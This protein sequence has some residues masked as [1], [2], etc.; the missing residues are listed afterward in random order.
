MLE[1]HP[2][3]AF[4]PPNAQ[5][6]ILGSFPGKQSSVS[7]TDSW[8]W[9]YGNPRNH[10]W[11]ILEGVYGV[12]LKDIN[13]KKKLLRSLGMAITDIIYQCERKLGSN[14]DANLT[15]IVYNTDAIG[16]ILA[17][18]DIEKIFFSSRFV[19]SNF[20][21]HFRNLT[22]RY[23]DLELITLPSPSP[24]YATMALAEKAKRYQDLLPKP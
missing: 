2:F 6:L 16:K 22:Q 23:P 1:T 9:F 21:S 19:E 14:L 12:K 3:G 17:E 11:Q 24:R 20:K 10:F 4:V 13:D 5:Y 15:N 8:G 7:A 18:N